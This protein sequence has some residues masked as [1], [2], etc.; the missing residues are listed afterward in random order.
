MRTNLTDSTIRADEIGDLRY[1][2]AGHVH[3]PLGGLHHLQVLGAHKEPLGRVDGV[4]IDPVQRRLRFF[5]VASND[6]LERHYLL[7]IDVPTRMSADRRSLELD[8]DVE[9][10]DCAE[11]ARSAARDF[12][13]DDLL[14]ALFR[15]SA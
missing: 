2:D 13:D 6:P 9:L 12:S 14:A 1:L 5:V 4:L 8:A 7:P 15:R 3:S 11:F 10:H